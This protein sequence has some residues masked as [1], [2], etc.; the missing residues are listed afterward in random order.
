MQGLDKCPHINSSIGGAT[1]AEVKLLHDVAL[2][3]G[4]RIEAASRRK[5]KE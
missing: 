2:L 4:A 5:V 1:I 3:Y